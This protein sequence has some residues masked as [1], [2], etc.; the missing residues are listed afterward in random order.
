MSECT[1]TNGHIQSW[2]R[3]EQNENQ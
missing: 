3:T 2:G 1:L